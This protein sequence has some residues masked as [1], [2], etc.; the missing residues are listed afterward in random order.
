MFFKPVQ[1]T[2]AAMGVLVMDDTACTNHFGLPLFLVVGINEHGRNQIIASAFLFNRTSDQFKEFLKWVQERLRP[3][4]HKM[5]S[6][7][8]PRSPKNRI[9]ETTSP[10]FV[11]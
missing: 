11:G 9:S 4:T 2:Q 8:L 3:D 1:D 7:D 10:Q 5:S 6:F